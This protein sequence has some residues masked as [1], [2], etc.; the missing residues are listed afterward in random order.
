MASLLTKRKPASA[1]RPR[2]AAK[3]L[4]AYRLTLLLAVT[5]IVLAAMAVQFLLSYQT[6]AAQRSELVNRLAG[7]EAQRLGATVAFYRALLRDLAHG[8]SFRQRLGSQSTEQVNAYLA[9]VAANFPYAKALRLLPADTKTPNDALVPPLG[10]ACL[11][12]LREAGNLNEVAPVEVHQHGTAEQHVDAIYAV[13]G[14]DGELLA[15]LQFVLD[16]DVVGQWLGNAGEQMLLE[17]SQRIGPAEQFVLRRVGDESLA[18]A[19]GGKSREIAGTRWQLSVWQSQPGDTGLPPL[20]FWLTLVLAVT[21]GAATIIVIF[22]RLGGAL[23]H[24]LA[25][26][27]NMT[28]DTLLGTKR[29]EHDLVLKEAKLAAMLI[30]KS[31]RATLAREHDLGGGAPRPRAERDVSAV[32]PMFLAR[33]GVAVEEIDDAPMSPPAEKTMPTARRRTTPPESFPPTE[34]VRRPEPDVAPTEVV[35]RPEPPAPATSVAGDDDDHVLVIEGLDEM[36][37]GAGPAL[38]Q[39]LFRAYDIRGIVGETLT[40]ENIYAIGKAIGS[41]A[42]ARGQRRLAFARDGRASGPELG[43]GLVE[44]LRE[45]G[46]DIVDLGMVPTPVLNFGAHR[47]A[48]G[49]GVMLTGSHNPPQYNGVKVSIGGEAL[50][51]D[52]IESLRTR[53]LQHDF[54]SGSGGYETAKVVDDYVTGI[55][56]DVRLQRPLKVVADCANGVAGI[57]VPKLLQALG[58]E[59]TLLFPEADGSFPNHAPDPSQTENLQALVAA[60]RA[61]DADL[62]VAFDGDADRL[63]VVSSDGKIVW[64]DRLLML[65]AKD[66]LAR[67]PGAEIIFDI[68]CSA[69]LPR[70]IAEHGGRP[71]MWRTGHSVLRAKLKERNAALAG[72]MSGHIFFADRWYGYDDAPYALARLLEI[73]SADLRQPRVVFAGL[74]Q[75]PSTPELRINVAEGRQH[76]LMEKVLATAQFDDAQ[77]ATIDGLR[78]DFA[79]GWGLVRASNTTPSLVLRFEARSNEALQSIQQRFRDLLHRIEPDLTLPF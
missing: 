24:D 22:M 25:N 56:R 33:D 23:K 12:L 27:V 65:F 38:P 66:V 68:K 76:V 50:S 45:T 42:L 63:V 17:L 67:Q 39:S 37:A 49:S 15:Y 34:V 21:A 7:Q 10:F 71:L 48:N 31:E 64:P 57:V 79:D 51:R 47:L 4:A 77:I 32:D 53:A 35:R 6:H 11:D 3:S 74:P 78:A 18:G 16:V 73:L 58:C 69:E 54:A 1:R 62:G 59:H 43:L 13:R 46:V 72:E 55:V 19:G 8:E 20:S 41:E 75:L 36:L 5:L 44:G 29:H 2:V 30:G 60:V 40:R 52:A 14:G 28:T 26:L 61:E 70:F 9:E